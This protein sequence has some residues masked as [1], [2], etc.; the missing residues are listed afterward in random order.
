MQ[1]EG[2]EHFDTMLFR[3]NA[4]FELVLFDRLP[5][6]QQQLLNA[7]Q[8]DTDCHGVLYPLQQ[9]ELGIRSV[10]QDTALLFSTLQRPGHIPAYVKSQLGA[11][12]HTTLLRFVLDTILEVEWQ[13]SWVSG[14][15]FYSLFFAHQTPHIV[16]GTIAQLSLDAVKYAQAL[17]STNS[18]QLSMRLYCY[19]RVP[20]SAHWWRKFPTTASVAAYLDLPPHSSSFLS[21][22]QWV[23][24][25]SNSSSD[26]WFA[27]SARYTPSEIHIPHF[28]YKLYISPACSYIRDAFQ[29]TIKVLA[30]SQ[31][32][33]FKIGRDVYGLLR[34]DK[35]VVYFASMQACEEMATQ[36]M[37]KLAGLP[38]HGVPFSSEIGGAGLLSWGIDPPTEEQTFSGHY[39]ESW[40]LWVT[41]RLAIALLNAK[42]TCPC[43]VEPWQFALERLRLD[44]VNIETWTPPQLSWQ[45]TT[46]E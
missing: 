9:P 33:H 40:R 5:V 32:M 42:S 31:A 44:D 2:L 41:N 38:A 24:V 20:L 13:G 23:E 22:Q 29:T 28:T 46:R 15:E 27:W 37:R 6:E 35:F 39:G 10:D 45:P 36:L 25:S 18:T 4:A 19:N 34:P 17:A 43:T 26:G 16:Q 30:D 11:E 12:Y 14:I 8:R 3:A 1:Q 7:L 21:K